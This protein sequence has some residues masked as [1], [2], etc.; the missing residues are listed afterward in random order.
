MWSQIVDDRVEVAGIRLDT[1][2]KMETESAAAASVRAPNEQS[3]RSAVCTMN[4]QHQCHVNG[5]PGLSVGLFSIF[6]DPFQPKPYPT[7]PPYI[8]KQSAFN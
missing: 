8:E 3:P 7:E 4:K 6:I 2:G 5:V 1:F